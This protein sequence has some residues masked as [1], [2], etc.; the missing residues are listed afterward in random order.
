MADPKP[1]ALTSV[2]SNA[3]DGPA[4]QPFVAVGGIPASTAVAAL[5][6]IT[7][8]DATDATTTQALVN[9]VK[10]KVNAIIAA[11]TA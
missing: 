6:A 11:L 9:E 2:A 3:Y 8:A 4:P 7:T 1:I 5:T 10:A